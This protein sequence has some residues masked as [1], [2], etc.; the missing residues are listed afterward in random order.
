M[1]TIN[2]EEIK[3]GKSGQYELKDYNITSLG[4]IVVHGDEENSEFD[5]R[6]FVIDYTYKI[7]N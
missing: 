2:G 4:L 7:E 1:F 6:N 5:T 3:L